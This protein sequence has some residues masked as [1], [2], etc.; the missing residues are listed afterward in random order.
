VLEELVDRYGDLPAE[1][2]RLAVVSRLR[3]VCRDLGITE[4]V[5]TGQKI[6]FS[7]V[8]LPDSGQVRLKRLFPAAMYRPTPKTVLIPVPKQGAGMRAVALRDLE[9]V[10]WCADAMTD[11]AA[12]P[13]RNLLE[14]EPVTR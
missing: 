6:S 13:R 7:P 9:L 1:V 11:L 12:V 5:Q 3:L 10:Q 8:T 2:G 14:P 4:V